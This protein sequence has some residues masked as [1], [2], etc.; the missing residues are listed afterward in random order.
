ME[1]QPSQFTNSS[2]APEIAIAL[3]EIRYANTKNKNTVKILNK[4]INEVNLTDKEIDEI[5]IENNENNK[6]FTEKILKIIEKYKDDTTSTIARIIGK[7]CNRESIQNV[8]KRREIR[9]KITLNLLKK[10]NILSKT[11]K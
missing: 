11:K 3:L 1:I 2:T 7:H 4:I 8:K 9:R 5:L 6:V 10:E